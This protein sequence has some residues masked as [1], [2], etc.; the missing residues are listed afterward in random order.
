L[1]SASN[2]S[3]QNVTQVILT[4]S[5]SKESRLVGKTLSAVDILALR[6]TY[7]F[8]KLRARRPLAGLLKRLPEQLRE[9]LRRRSLEIGH[10]KAGCRGVA[11]TAE[12]ARQFG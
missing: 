4:E 5:A 8:E 1:N 10:R 7:S 9:A 6:L 11:A 2:F 3:N 12:M